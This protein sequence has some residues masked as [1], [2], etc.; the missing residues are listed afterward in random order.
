MPTTI[1]RNRER[2]L[3][4]QADKQGYRLTK[5]RG[6]DQDGYWLTDM[7]TGALVVG[8]SPARGVFIGHDLDVIENYLRITQSEN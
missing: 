5:L 7:D 2:R 8:S 6:K 4:R 3:R 1:D